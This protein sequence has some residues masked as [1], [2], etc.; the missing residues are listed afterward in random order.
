MN[1][2]FP[3]QLVLSSEGSGSSARAEITGGAGYVDGDTYELSVIDA[4]GVVVYSMS[5]ATTYAVHDVCDTQCSIA[6]LD[7]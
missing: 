2:S 7:L 1:G 4:D 6:M 5:R 3:A